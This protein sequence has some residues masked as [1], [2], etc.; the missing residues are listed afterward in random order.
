MTSEIADDDVKMEVMDE[1]TDAKKEPAGASE[2]I[3]SEVH[4]Q[5]N[6]N[7]CDSRACSPSKP[8]KEEQVEET[9]R[10]KKKVGSK[11]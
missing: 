3:K 7:E 9:A 4:D 8:A 5:D 6:D 10:K 2:G 11:H 1:W